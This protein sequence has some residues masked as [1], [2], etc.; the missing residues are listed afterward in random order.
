MLNKEGLEISKTTI[1]VAKNIYKQIDKYHNNIDRAKNKIDK[2]DQ[3]LQERIE[4]ERQKSKE[5][6]AEFYQDIEDNK[7]QISTVEESINNLLGVDDYKQVLF[8]ED[9]QPLEIVNNTD[10]EVEESIDL[11]SVTEQVEESVVTQGTPQDSVENEEDSDQPSED[12]VEPST[13]D[14]EDRSEDDPF[15]W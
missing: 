1:S 13:D 11:E 6:V 2:E 4:K 10:T 8:P 7:V 9:T 12:T 15:G 3:R 14:T 5:R